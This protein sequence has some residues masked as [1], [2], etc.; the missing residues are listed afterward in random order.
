[1]AVVLDQSRNDIARVLT[2]FDRAP[3]AHGGR[4]RR[5]VATS[6]GSF[7]DNALVTIPF[8]EISAVDQA[9]PREPPA[10]RLH[11]IP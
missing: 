11:V 1:V 6:P 2:A 3:I 4:R 9:R 10:T 5:P 8:V 7:P